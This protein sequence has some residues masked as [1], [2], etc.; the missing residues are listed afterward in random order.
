MVVR[1]RDADGPDPPWLDPGAVRDP[2]SAQEW[3]EGHHRF[4]EAEERSIP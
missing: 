4:V 2:V 1:L 3:L